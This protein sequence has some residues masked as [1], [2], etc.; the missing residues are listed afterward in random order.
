MSSRVNVAIIT[1]VAALDCDSLKLVI[2]KGF[3]ILNASC[4][5]K[6]QASGTVPLVL[7]VRPKSGDAQN[8]NESMVF[9]EP[10]A[11]IRD[12]DDAFGNSCQRVI[13]EAG[14]STIFATCTVSVPDHIDVHT[15]ANFTLV[16]DLPD[17][18]LL[19]LLPSRFCQSDMMLDLATE[20]T[21]KA[22]PGYAQVDAIRSWIHDNIK[23]EYGTSGPTTTAMDTVKSRTG[24]CRDYS[25][26]GIA[27]CRSL[28]IPARMV[29][30]YLHNL[31]PMDL[32]AWFEAFIGGRWYTF[33][34]TQDRPRGNR[35][36]LAYGRDAADVAQLSEY[37][38]LEM[39]HMDVTVS[40][41]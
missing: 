3:M 12:Y 13:L 18:T 34:A 8:V 40:A 30:G 9:V 23:Y 15:D 27:L 21:A 19:Y 17:G 41:S 24:V 37:G 11:P 22:E 4:Q 26:L 35:I 16:Q 33:D 6:V 39:K 28:R 7:M 32:H 25:H 38:P 36:V 20:I 2:P 1:A 14:P 5:M 10:S 31:D 29:S